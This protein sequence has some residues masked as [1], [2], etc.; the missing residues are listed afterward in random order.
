MPLDYDDLVSVRLVEFVAAHT[1][2]DAFVL[3]RGYVY[4]DGEQTCQYSRRIFMRTGSNLVV[5]YRSDLFPS[6]ATN[7]SPPPIG[8]LDWPFIASHIKDPHRLCDS[9]GLSWMTVPFPAIIWRRS[10]LSISNA[11]AP[12]ARPPAHQT[13]GIGPISRLLQ[14]AKQK[15][16]RRRLNPAL[17]GEF[18]CEY[19]TDLGM[20][21]C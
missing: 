18:G 1:N 5:R 4:N 6:E 13:R 20:K 3:S 19:G 15:L 8:Y 17:C 12:S 2:T 14:G 7:F 11:Y 9:L 21:D 10:V 16:L